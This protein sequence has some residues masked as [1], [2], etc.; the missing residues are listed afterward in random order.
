MDN[1]WQFKMVEE[2]GMFLTDFE[3]APHLA[4]NHILS[5]TTLI[6]GSKVVMS[7]GCNFHFAHGILKDNNVKQRMKLMY[8]R[9]DE[10]RTD[11]RMLMM[12]VYIPDQDIPRVYDMLS[13]ILRSQESKAVAL[14]PRLTKYFV[15]GYERPS[16]KSII[17]PRFPPSMWSCYSRVM[18]DKPSTTNFLEGC[19]RGYDF[20]FMKN[21]PSFKDFGSC[22]AKDIKAVEKDIGLV[23]EN[24]ENLV[25]RK[26]KQ[27]LE[28]TAAIKASCR[29]YDEKFI[30]DEVMDYLRNLAKITS[31]TLRC[32]SIDENE[33]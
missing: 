8:D 33:N 30:K 25:Q 21:H 14:L 7:S 16:D 28:R 17:L 12:L 20:K 2:G 15:H 18:E 3:W 1:G 26:R 4:K 23:N 9:S 19:H 22:L 32:T 29:M 6:P 13:D 11:V 5:Q 24:K 31:R 10:H 27:E